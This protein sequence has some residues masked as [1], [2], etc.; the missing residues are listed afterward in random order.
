[1]IICND[2]NIN[3]RKS[4]ILFIKSNDIHSFS[5]DLEKVLKIEY[6]IENK[7]KFIKLLK[8]YLFKIE[9]FILFINSN[10]F[11]DKL[12]DLN[13]LRKFVNYVQIKPKDRMSDDYHLLRFGFINKEHRNKYGLSLDKFIKRYGEEKGE[14]KYKE[15]SQLQKNKSRYSINYWMENGYSEADS[16]KILSDLQSSHTKKHLENK[17][18]EYIQ[19]YHRSNSPWRVEYYLNRGYTEKEAKEIISKIKKESSMF[20]SEYYQKLGHTI[21][22]SN[23]LSYEYWKEH[24]YKNN[25]NV[26]KES[27]K[28]FSVI[29]ERIKD[30]TNICVYYGDPKIDKKE[31]FLYD[32]SEKRYY[33]YDFTILKDDLKIIIEYNGSKFHPRKYSLT[34]EEWKNWR[35]LFNEDIDADTKYK[36]DCKKR[37]LA[38]DNG[39]QYLEIWSDD[40]FDS[41]IEKSIDFILQSLQNVV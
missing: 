7:I 27:L 4:L 20:C 38:L 5:G 9:T 13:R 10:N 30:L 26:S 12:F 16:Y 36:Y 11:N 40:V 24:C 14:I 15:Y 32:K 22:E 34:E 17:S 1:M 2:I 23:D 29:Y 28:I 41:N 8:E 21:E 39:F 18:K 35:C 6:F 37:D 25:S 33:F 19:E 3:S 31:Y